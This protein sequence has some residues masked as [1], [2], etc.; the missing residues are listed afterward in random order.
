V[1]EVLERRFASMGARLSLAPRPWNGSPRI[2]VRSDRAGELFDIRFD[3]TGG[4]ADIEVVDLSARDRHLLLLVR[5]G[6]EKSKF[7]CGHDERHWFVAAIPE[8]A[9]GVTGV[10]TAKAALQPKAVRDLVE[11]ARPKDPFRR[12]NA[13]YVRQG[14][15]FF[16]PWPALQV[17]EAQVL[18]NEPLSRGRGK[19]HVMQFVYRTGGTA[20][21]INDGRLPG[22][23]EARYERLSPKQRTNGRWVRFVRDPEMYAKGTVRHPDHATIELP[24]WHRVLMNTEQG[25]RAMRHVAFLD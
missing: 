9:R 22:I 17:V 7:L 1:N 16:L 2:D 6:G 21:W 18:R 25:A 12:R 24:S 4:D 19:P 10:K 15:W 20:V 13:L 8:A 23:S 5:S 3:G 11:R 14:E